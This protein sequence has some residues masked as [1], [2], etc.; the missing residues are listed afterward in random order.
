[1]RIG[2]IGFSIF[3]RPCLDKP[4]PRFWNKL[5]IARFT[6][7]CEN[8]APCYCSRDQAKLLCFRDGFC[9]NFF[10][11][12]N[13]SKSIDGRVECGDCWDDTEASG[14]GDCPARQIVNRVDKLRLLLSRHC[15]DASNGEEIVQDNDDL[16]KAIPGNAA[17][18]TA[19]KIRCR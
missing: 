8:G 5:L 18:T 14:N 6:S 7:R 12:S 2:D 10:G 3:R 17:S 1:M 11:P 4:F 9:G 19:I 16:S 13:G 15:A